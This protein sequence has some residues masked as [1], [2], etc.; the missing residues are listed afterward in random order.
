MDEQKAT[1]TAPASKVKVCTI[2]F[3]PE[4]WAALNH[5]LIDRGGLSLSAWA[6]KKADEEIASAK[7][8]Q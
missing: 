4:K 6:N 7:Q 8:P 1:A 5:I 3:S 2:R